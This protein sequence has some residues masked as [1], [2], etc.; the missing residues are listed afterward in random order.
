[1]GRWFLS[2]DRLR[3]NATGNRLKAAAPA[4]VTGKVAPLPLAKAGKAGRPWAQA[5]I[6][7]PGD[8]PVQKD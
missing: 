4:T 7:K 8:L 5:R 6:R 1:M 2:Y 3:G